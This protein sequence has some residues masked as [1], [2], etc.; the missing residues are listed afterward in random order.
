MEKQEKIEA[1]TLKRVLKHL[2][3]NPDVQNI[4]LM[5]CTFKGESKLTD[6]S[7][8]L[9]IDLKFILQSPM[10]QNYLLTKICDIDL[11]LFKVSSFP[12]FSYVFSCQNVVK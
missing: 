11:C 6:K 4:D 2:R 10:F 8:Q 9:R 12:P 3:D 1:A 7:H 5:N